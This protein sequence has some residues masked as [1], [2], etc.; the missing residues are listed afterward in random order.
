MKLQQ[1]RCEDWKKSV[2]QRFLCTQRQ[3]MEFWAQQRRAS[4]LVVIPRVLLSASVLWLSELSTNRTTVIWRFPP[5]TFC[6]AINCWAEWKMNYLRPL[7]DQQGLNSSN[8]TLSSLTEIPPL[9][10][11]ADVLHPHP[12]PSVS[13]VF[14]YFPLAHP[15][16]HRSERCLIICLAK[17]GSFVANHAPRYIRRIDSPCTRRGRARAWNSHDEWANNGRGIEFKNSRTPPDFARP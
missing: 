4:S 10:T 13:N 8:L 11:L 16:A 5:L 12:N 3:R 1:K 6:V 2:T 17:A 7:M 14:S 15:K 9:S